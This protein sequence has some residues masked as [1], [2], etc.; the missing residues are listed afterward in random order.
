[1]VFFL[2]LCYTLS[3][4]IT[5]RS[6]MDRKVY[7]LR[8][9]YENEHAPAAGRESQRLTQRELSKAAGVSLGKTNKLIAECRSDGLMEDDPALGLRLTDAGLR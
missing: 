8:R 7:I 4:V 3:Y 9:I 5:E 1:M 6:V 2:S